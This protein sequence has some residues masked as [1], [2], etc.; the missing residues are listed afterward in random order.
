MSDYITVRQA[1]RTVG[2]GHTTIIGWCIKDQVDAI[3][4]GD[5]WLVSLRSVVDKD[6]KTP[7]RNRQ[8]RTHKSEQHMILTE[9]C[10]KCGGDKWKRQDA[11]LLD[12]GEV[13]LQLKC[14][15]HLCGKRWSVRLP[16]GTKIKRPTSRNGREYN[17]RPQ[18]ESVEE[19]LEE[20][21]KLIAD[22]MQEGKDEKTIVEIFGPKLRS[23][24]QKIYRQESK[25]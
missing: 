7:K 17:T 3:K 2:R 1:S 6:K 24:V 20:R 15:D 11:E 10:P 21:R 19:I 25:A 16:A 4:D 12:S 13:S 23:Q 18:P 14:L 9:R 22:L 8:V 5:R